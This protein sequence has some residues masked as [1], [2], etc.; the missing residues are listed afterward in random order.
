MTQARK[1]LAALFKYKIAVEGL[2]TLAKCILSLEN[3]LEGFLMAE[4]SHLEVSAWIKKLGSLLHPP[5]SPNQG[6]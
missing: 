5:I 1:T 4:F 2:Q 3:T 6:G